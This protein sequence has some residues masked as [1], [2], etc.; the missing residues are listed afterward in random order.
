M[1]MKSKKPLI[2]VIIIIIVCAGLYFC[3]RNERVR[4]IKR[5]SG[6]DISS[7]RILKDKDTHGG[8]LGDGEYIL[9]AD[10]GK[11][12]P[13]AEELKEWKRLPLTENLQ[14]MMYGP[15]PDEYEYSLAGEAGIPYVEN[16]YY[17]FENRHSGAKS[18]ES[19]E[20]LFDVISFN[21]TLA[22][23]DTDNEMFYFYD[24]DT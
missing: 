1:Y 12:P 23:Y 7:C 2:I 8:F 13:S 10:C 18:R 15:E 21:F 16:G 9:I 6:F 20:D 14:L 19:D 5:A 22:I 11:A 17:Y 24:I 4:Y 3:Y